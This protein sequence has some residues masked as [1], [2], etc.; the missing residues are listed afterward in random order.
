LQWAPHSAPHVLVLP[1]S[2]LHRS[3]HV[4]LQFA[5]DLQSKLQSFPH[6][7]P[8]SLTLAQAAPQPSPH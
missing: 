4:T 8:Q 1:H 2:M 6:A 5:T 3:A 7:A